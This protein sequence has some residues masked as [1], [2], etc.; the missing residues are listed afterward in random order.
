M[1]VDTFW[2]ITTVPFGAEM[3]FAMRSAGAVDLGQP[4]APRGDRLG[5]PQLEEL[6]EVVLRLGRDA[7]ERVRDEVDAFLERGELRAVLEQAVGDGV[8][9]ARGLSC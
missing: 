1:I 8:G 9:H 5:P 4:V 3:I 7:A 2:C 6:A